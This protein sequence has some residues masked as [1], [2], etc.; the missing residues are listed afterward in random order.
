[1]AHFRG[2]VQGS[3]G[4]VSRLGS[5]KSGLSVYAQGWCLGVHVMADVVDGQDV[6]TIYRTS[7]SNSAG[8]HEKVAV[9]TKDMT[10]VEI[11]K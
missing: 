5:A 1:M 11:K 9:I 4:I 8:V 7:G 3:K 6:F 10:S 2:T